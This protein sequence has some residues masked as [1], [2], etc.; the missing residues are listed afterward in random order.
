VTDVAIWKLALT[1]GE[2]LSPKLLFFLF[3]P[4]VLDDWLV[5]G[6]GVG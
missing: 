3:V 5:V 1:G 2:R 6:L 4:G